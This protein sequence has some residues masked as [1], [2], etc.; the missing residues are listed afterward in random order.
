MTKKII[1]NEDVMNFE[2]LDRVSG[3]SCFETSRDSKFLNVLLRGNFAQCDR[4]GAFKSK[5]FDQ[6][7]QKAW[8]A[9]GISCKT[10]IFSANVYEAQINGKW[11]KIT[12]E[13]AYEYA[14]SH[15]GKKL[16]RSDWDW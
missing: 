13:E 4:Y 11:K 8:M 16:N 12:Q 15:I 3:G 1:L 14:Q 6:E 9:A 7:I 2:E 5:F 10:D